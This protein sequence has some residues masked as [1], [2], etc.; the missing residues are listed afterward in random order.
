MDALT[1]EVVTACPGA[2]PTGWQRLSGGRSNLCWRLQAPGCDLVLKLY[3]PGRAGPV[4][5]NDPDAEAACLRQLEGRSL[6]PRPV[7]Q[8]QGALGPCLVYRHLPGSLWQGDTARVAR[9]LRRLHDGPVPDA[10]ARSLRRAADGSTALRAEVSAQLGDLPQAA[11]VLAGLPSREVP[12]LARPMLLHGDPVAGNLVETP[13]GLRLID[14]QCPALGDPCL[15]LATF[16]SPA[17]SHLYLGRV[18]NAV[19][20]RAFLQAYD[21]PQI[22]RRLRALQPFLSAR[23]IAHCLH[24]AAEGSV[25][26]ARAAELEQ[27]GWAI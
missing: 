6:A 11:S 14:W 21:R 12:P 7:A 26:D 3:R 16:L 10:L 22:T 15:D 2:A 8:W 20:A 23:M 27:Q 1:E 24:R 13:D 5:P 17:M 4:F 25:E 18:L 9:L 19:E